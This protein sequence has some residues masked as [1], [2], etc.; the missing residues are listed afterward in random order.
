METKTLAGEHRLNLTRVDPNELVDELMN[1][2]DFNDKAA[3]EGKNYWPMAITS[4]IRFYAGLGMRFVSRENRLSCEL[5]Q[6]HPE[7]QQRN[8]SCGEGPGPF[9]SSSHAL[10][11]SF[12]IPFRSPPFVTGSGV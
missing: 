11:S 12:F 9:P 1:G 7:A 4:A 2:I 5:Y 10:P 3:T 6:I 8:L